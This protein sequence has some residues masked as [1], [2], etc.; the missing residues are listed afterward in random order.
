MHVIGIGGSR[1]GIL[2]DLKEMFDALGGIDVDIGDVLTSRVALKG[3]LQMT[4][5][6]RRPD[7]G[8]LEFETTYEDTGT[9]TRVWKV[10]QVADLAPGE[11]IWEYICNEN[12]QDAEHMTGK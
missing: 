4:T 6:I 8:H 5:R 9:F 12:N 1:N 11:E 3:Q 2:D 10:K 7:L